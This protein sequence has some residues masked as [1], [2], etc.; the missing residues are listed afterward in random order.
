MERLV[1]E[2]KKCGSVANYKANLD[3]AVSGVRKSSTCQYL[4]HRNSTEEQ[5]C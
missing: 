3:T 1:T 5:S 2:K 4:L